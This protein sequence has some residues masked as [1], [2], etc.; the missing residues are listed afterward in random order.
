MAYFYCNDEVE[1]T[2]NISY[3]C[4]GITINIDKGSKGK[5]VSIDRDGFSSKLL[6]SVK[7]NIAPTISITV[8]IEAESL[9]KDR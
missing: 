4:D 9:N 3:L 1:L 5:I 8:P 2:K 6:C 7:L